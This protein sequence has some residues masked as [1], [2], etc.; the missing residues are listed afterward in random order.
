MSSPQQGC[1]VLLDRSLM[2]DKKAATAISISDNTPRP[3]STCLRRPLPKPSPRRGLLL[4]EETRPRRFN[5]FDSAEV[6]PCPEARGVCGAAEAASSRK[7]GT[8]G[9]CP[10]FDQISDDGFDARAEAASSEVGKNQSFCP[11]YRPSRGC[12]VS[13]PPCYLLRTTD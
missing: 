7:P 6:L 12:P 4:L 5:M 8:C 11:R 2:T 10:G 3:M 1:A 13:T 9:G